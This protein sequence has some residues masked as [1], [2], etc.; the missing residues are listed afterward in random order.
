VRTVRQ[1]IEHGH[2]KAGDRLVGHDRS[3]HPTGHVASLRADG[4][5]QLDDGQIAVDLDAA[6]RLAQGVRACDGWTF[7]WV[8][9]RAGLTPLDAVRQSAINVGDL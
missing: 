4:A 8:E 1:L 2:L 7:W 9:Q 5:V 6:G 3:R